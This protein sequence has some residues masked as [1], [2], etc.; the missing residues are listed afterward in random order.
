MVLT[1]ACSF[2]SK[3]RARVHVPKLEMPAQ[4]RGVISGRV[5]GATMPWC[6]QHSLFACL[7]LSGYP[8]FVCFLFAPSVVCKGRA[9][10]SGGSVLERT[11]ELTHCPRSSQPVP[12]H[13]IARW[14]WF[15]GSVKQCLGQIP[16]GNMKES[17]IPLQI[18]EGI[19]K[20][21]LFFWK[22]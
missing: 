2:R 17:R 4:K 19:A 16:I 9:L 7:G 12:E 8:I 20:N 11:A 3:T 10:L 13:A 22:V 14:S 18:L 15:H 6:K 1:I 5:H 21:L